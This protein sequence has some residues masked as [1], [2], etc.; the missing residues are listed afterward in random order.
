MTNH[1]ELNLADV[2]SYTNLFS[3]L[4]FWTQLLN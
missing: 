1:I 3:T 4:G 2:L